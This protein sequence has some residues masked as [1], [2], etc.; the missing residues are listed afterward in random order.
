MLDAEKVKNKNNNAAKAPE[1]KRNMGK[2]LDGHNLTYSEIKV[3]ASFLGGSGRP[4]NVSNKALR[5]TGLSDE[6]VK[7]LENKGYLEHL[8]NGDYLLPRDVDGNAIASR[9]MEQSN[10]ERI[11]QMNSGKF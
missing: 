9:L 11:R 7:D 6:D 10:C 8:T 4:M 1:R 2:H 3:L 5:E